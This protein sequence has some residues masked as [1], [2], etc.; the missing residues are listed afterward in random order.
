MYV[1]VS[2]DLLIPFLGRLEGSHANVV[3][4]GGAHVLLPEVHL[5]VAD[6]GLEV[7]LT[8]LVHYLLDPRKENAPVQPNENIISILQDFCCRKYMP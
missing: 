4:G 5:Q 3:E 6:R 2:Y 8:N 1:Y 7:G